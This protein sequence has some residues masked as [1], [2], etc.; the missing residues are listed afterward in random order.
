[1]EIY[2]IF[3]FEAAHRLPNVPDGHKCARL[4]GHSFEVTLYVAGPVDD[5]TGWVVDFADVKAAFKPYLN[6]LDHYYL[7]EIDGLE[8]P[9]SENI[10]R[11]IWRKVK[12]ALPGLSKVAVKETCTAGCVYRGEDEA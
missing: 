11:W 9:T 7:N 12:T 1:M 10:A 8:N 3:T 4:H 5:H 6:Q 2:K